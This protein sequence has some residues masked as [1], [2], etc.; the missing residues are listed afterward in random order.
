MPMTPDW[1]C[2]VIYR[3][4]GLNECWWHTEVVAIVAQPMGI[5]APEYR[6][7]INTEFSV[8]ATLKENLPPWLPRN[9][10]HLVC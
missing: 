1:I 4:N 8:P 10:L 3:D 2:L 7:V 6:Y 5:D 9:A